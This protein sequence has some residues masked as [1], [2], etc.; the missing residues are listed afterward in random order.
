M[1]E[2]KYIEEKDNRRIEEPDDGEM[3][4][5]LVQLFAGMWKS[6]RRLWWLVLLLAVI[7][8]AGFYAFQTLRFEPMYRC[9]T[10]F[11]VATGDEN[12]GSY[13]FYY[14]SSTADQLSRTFPYILDSSFFRSALLER[15]NKTELDGTI[16]S[17]VIEDSNMVT[18]TVTSP[19]AEDAKAILDAAL[20]IYPETAR[21]ILGRIE[22][23]I[24][25]ESEVP[26]EP[27]NTF[28]IAQC[29]VI[30]GGAGVLAGL[31]ILGLLALFRRTA[32]NPEE[33]K[34]ITSLR[35]LAAVPQVR[36]KARRTQGSRVISVLDERISYGYRES[37]RALQIRLQKALD[38]KKNKILLITSTVPGEGKSTL[39]VNLS[40]MFASR[41]FN[42]LL[43]D[44]DLR[45]QTDAKLAGAEGTCGLEEAVK[46][47]KPAWEIIHKVKKSHVWFLGAS[48]PVR[49][50]AAVLGSPGLAPFLK[51]MKKKMDYIIIDAPP[52]E[53]IQ[54]AAAFADYADGILYVVKHDAVPQRKLK[55]GF[56]SFRGRKASFLGYVFNFY[57]ESISEYGYG[58]Y[59][60]GS[61]G[62]G[63]YGYGG[64]GYG[65]LKKKE[66]KV[67]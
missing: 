65:Y 29:C 12:S 2:A 36:F 10:T 37:I 3:E 28:S 4:I 32:R 11:T 55:E 53:M 41:G 48:E 42:V 50:P 23:N 57:P 54:D 17:E 35:C 60:Y 34:K 24:L 13:S 43:I 1:K 62:Y 46:G 27:Y 6:L 9:S 67:Q 56:S 52:C 39:A 20:E 59:G 66:K 38:K 15:L 16:T 22:F 18:L 44:G 31:F 30:G 5:D 21:F 51:E 63:R 19:D 33:M 8:A 58:R 47:E 64:K 14:D 26:R 25:N 7:G 40:E 49:N 61:Y 45:R